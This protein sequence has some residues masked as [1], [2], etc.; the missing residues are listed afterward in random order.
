MERRIK[1]KLIFILYSWFIYNAYVF[2]ITPIYI[3]DTDFLSSILFALLAL[4]SY[5]SIIAFLMCL[6]YIFTILGFIL[7]LCFFAGTISFLFWG[8]KQTIIRAWLLAE[9]GMF[10]GPGIPFVF[11]H[12]TIDSGYVSPFYGILGLNLLFLTLLIGNYMQKKFWSNNRVMNKICYILKW[13]CL[14]T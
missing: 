4:S 5:F 1:K 11:F 14:N 2:T 10:M 12:N 13:P 6:P 9:T 8:R 7:G 3:K